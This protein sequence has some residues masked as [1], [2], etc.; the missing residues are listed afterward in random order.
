MVALVD[1]D[2][3]P[4]IGA[5]PRLAAV[6]YGAT[7]T[8]PPWRTVLNGAVRTAGPA[9]VT[10]Y[11]APGYEWLWG[12]EGN[13]SA[14]WSSAEIMVG[15]RVQALAYSAAPSFGSADQ[16]SFAEL[17]GIR[18]EI[19]WA[20]IN[21]INSATTVT[22]TAPVQP[23]Y[24]TGLIF[25]AVCSTRAAS[26]APSGVHSQGLTAI[27]DVA[28]TAGRMYVYRYLPGSKPTVAWTTPASGN[29]GLITAIIR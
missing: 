4:T 11:T 5:K 13:P 20:R 22:T 9:T 19:L 7:L 26:G 21:N 6:Q 17:A 12:P 16:Y 25:V 29:H 23:F 14:T 24:E 18:G 2:G 15:R 10:S 3:R 28:Q 1:Q 8:K 27:A